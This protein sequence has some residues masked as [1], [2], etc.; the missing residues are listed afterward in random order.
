MPAG[1]LALFTAL[2]TPAPQYGPYN[3]P[4]VAYLTDAELDAD[5]GIQYVHN[6][7]RNSRRLW[8]TVRERKRTRSV[9]D[10]REKNDRAF[11]KL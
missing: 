9:Q 8:D 2:I 3:G 11:R 1:A 7:T 6:T 4:F 5:E 10:F